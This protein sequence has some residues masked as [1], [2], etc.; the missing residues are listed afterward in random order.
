LAIITL[1]M[2][3]AL[4]A[5]D[6]ETVWSD[7][8]CLIIRT[9]LDK[10][11]SL[12]FY[13]PFYERIKSLHGFPFP[14]FETYIDF[15]DLPEDTDIFLCFGGDGTFLESLTHIR[16]KSIP[17]AGIN[18]GRLGFLT[19]ADLNSGVAWIDDLLAGKYTIEKRTILK[20]VSD[21]LPEDFFPYAVNEV[22]VQRKDS[23]MIAVDLAV[24]G[25]ELPTY[26]SD[27]LV[28][29]TPTGSTAYSLSIGGPIVLPV[30]KVWIIAPIAP[31][32]LN[33]RPL[34]VPD[35]S[36]LDLS[37]HSRGNAV[38]CLDNRD[39]PVLSGDSFKIIKAGFDLNYIS[40]QKS[41]FIN[42]LKDKL[43]WGED[44]RNSQI[45]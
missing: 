9:L 23:T 10:G 32:N 4:F 6:F 45:L 43:R 25:I 22:S 17:I 30:S 15:R 18:F 33:V 29:A 24:D 44:K 38:L 28:V 3:I 11:A 1:K 2:K 27:G 34:V 12:C 21:T 20:V 42:A 13:K 19:S 37:V 40:M 14:N 26:W 16:E 31:H 36:V 8:L 39:F 35:G 5:R 7:R 41:S